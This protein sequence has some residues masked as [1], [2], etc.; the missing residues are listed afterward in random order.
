[1]RETSNVVREG[2]DCSILRQ[3]RDR[4]LQDCNED[5]PFSHRFDETQCFRMQLLTSSEASI[6]P[7]LIASVGFSCS[8]FESAS[9]HTFLAI[10]SRNCIHRHITYRMVLAHTR[11][12]HGQQHGA[13][14]SVNADESINGVFLSCSFLAAAFWQG[15][16]AK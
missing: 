2:Y 13:R 15:H 6:D 9:T 4:M 3:A 8:P 5:V 16:S 14:L 12:D 1:M 11:T 7:T 10:H